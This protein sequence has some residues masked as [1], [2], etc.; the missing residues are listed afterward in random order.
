MVIWHISAL[1]LV[2]SRPLTLDE[3][4]EMAEILFDMQLYPRTLTLSSGGRV[5]LKEG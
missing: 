3:L 5:R 4:V 1:M 2:P